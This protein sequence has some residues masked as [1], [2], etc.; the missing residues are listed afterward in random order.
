MKTKTLF[1]ALAML[2]MIVAAEASAEAQKY[3]PHRTTVQQL[4]ENAEV[5]LVGQLDRVEDIQ[6]TV[7]GLDAA[8][9]KRLN[10][11]AIQDGEDFIRREGVITVNSVLKGDAAAIGSELRFVS[12]RQLKLAA[13]DTD[14]RTGEAVYFLSKRTEDGRY[15]IHDD[16]AV[17]VGEQ[18]L[19]ALGAGLD[20][21][22]VGED[23]DAAAGLDAPLRA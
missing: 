5:V 8:V 6:L 21:D 15:V 9:Y 14:M 12:I 10:D 16:V 23:V 17:E 13:Y 11:G 4:T 19:A 18:G 3:S 22:G 20:E 7:K 2:A 1:C